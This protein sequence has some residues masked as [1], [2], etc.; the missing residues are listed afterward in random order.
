MPR[1]FRPFLPLVLVLALAWAGCDAA[2]DDD[3]SGVVTLQG[4]VLNNLTNNP[5]TG[6]YVRVLPLDLLF[7]ADDEGRFDFEVE[8]DSTMDLQVVASADGYSQSTVTV[9]A[10]AGRVIPV[11][12]LR[13]TQTVDERPVSGRAWS[14]LL[15]D[16]S[17]EAIG[18]RESG[19]TEVASLTFMVADSVG[20][21]V[22]LDNSAL[23]RF[24]FG[25]RPGGGESL[26]PAESPTD[27]NG[28]ATVTL[29]S[30]TKAGH[31]QVIAS[32]TVA[33]RVIRSQPVALSIHGGLPD[34]A[35]FSIGPSVF[36]F[37]GLNVYG[38]ENE[39]SVIVGDQYANPVRPGTSVYFTTTHGVIEGS[40]ATDARGQGSVTLLSANPLPDDGIGVITA[41]TSDRNQAQV[42]GR[43]PVIFSGFPVL[44]VSPTSVDV[45]QTYQM[46]VTDQNGNPL[47]GGT[48]I[49]VAVEGTAVKG[50][51][52]TSVTLADY[53]FAGGMTYQHVV[54]G[55]G[56]TEFVFRAVPDID[57]NALNPETPVVEAITITVEGPN[58]GLVVVLGGAGKRRGITASEGAVIT[59]LPDGRF[60]IR[61]PDPRR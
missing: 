46:T 58:G 40:T 21:P 22:V 32:T 53:G 10:L 26:A 34:Q 36:N 30:G 39:M 59:E 18:V 15:L 51:G 52:A 12:P 29:S 37:P 28:Q 8:I 25:G 38:L 35:H 45:G 61:A 1:P 48:T 9:L 27:N 43:T 33:G 19:S 4:Q 20:R 11:P 42:I 54:R 56:V 3:T 49:T 13:L 16:Q 57:P 55:P 60:E 24:E 23:I 14:I 31:V 17:S 44:T 2:S 5:V 7:P 47:A 41:T 6:A 50:V